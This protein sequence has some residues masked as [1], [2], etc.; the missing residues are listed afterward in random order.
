MLNS[1]NNDVRAAANDLYGILLD[2]DIDVAYD[3]RDETPGV[4]FND[5]ELMGIPIQI[6][7]SSRNIK[8]DSFEI[9]IN[10]QVESTIVKTSEIISETMKIL[11]SIN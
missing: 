10:N 8:N 1:D 2:N 7:V 6:I 11:A 5:A 9:K 4:K 3:D